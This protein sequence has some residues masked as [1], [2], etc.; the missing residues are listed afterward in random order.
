MLWNVG[1]FV[2]HMARA[3]V[4]VV[5]SSKVLFAFHDRRSDPQAYLRLSRKPTDP[6]P[7]PPR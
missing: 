6:G 5:G 7:V 4:L 1:D 2:A 3:E